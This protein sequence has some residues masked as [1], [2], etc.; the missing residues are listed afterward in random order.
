MI[1]ASYLSLLESGELEKR[2]A[3][4]K[5]ALKNCVLCPHQCEVNRLDGEKGAC[6][7]LDLAIVSGA[8]PHFGEETEL[9]G[10]GGSGTIFFSNCNLRCVFCQNY[11]IS[12]C[13]E[14]EPWDPTELAQVM[15][16]LQRKGCH[17]INFVSP[18]HIIPQIVE[19]IY[20][21]AQNGLNIPIVYNT[22]SYDLTDSLRYL[23][24]I[25]DIYLPDIKFSDNER[26]EKYLGVK[27]YYSIAT[28]ALKEMYRQVGNLVTDQ[29]NVAIKGVMIR[30]LVMP[31]NLAGTKEI[32]KFIA[33]ELSPDTYVN[34]MAQYYP[35]YKSHKY[36]ELSR[37]LT[38]A[39]YSEAIKIAKEAGLT[40]LITH[41]F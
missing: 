10:T 17:N 6:F 24:G 14:G 29:N 39:E 15:V 2:V 19:S 41:S 7:T 22:G 28:D 40:R 23:E 33:D 12:H 38:R 32:M 21:A 25:V 35:S 4:L 34:L 5:E 31:S 16:Q 26:G 8:Q 11:E 36:D 27:E 30:H 9:V 3:K 20:I 1:K 13:G 18:S 37:G